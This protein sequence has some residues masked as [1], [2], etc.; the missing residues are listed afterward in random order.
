MK[1]LL[2]YLINGHA[3]EINDD[4]FAVGD[5]LSYD[6]GYNMILPHFLRVIEL[7]KT[8]KSCKV[9]ELE[10][11]L[12]S[13]SYNGGGKVVPRTDKKGKPLDKQYRI[14]MSSYYH[15]PFIKVDKHEAYL[16][17]GKP[18]TIDMND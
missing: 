12:V 11:E 18:E 7:N 9:E 14:Q 10:N 3:G 6:A 13:G 15:K 8:G 1:T 17:D 5:I 16:W 2:E 4:G